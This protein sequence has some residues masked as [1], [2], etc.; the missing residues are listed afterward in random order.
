M[1]LPQLSPALLNLVKNPSLTLFEV[2]HKEDHG[3]WAAKVDGE[4]AA[5]RFNHDRLGNEGVQD[6][7]VLRGSKRATEVVQLGF[8]QNWVSQEE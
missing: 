7:E 4:K 1:S 5:K 2:I 3:I 8:T 6:G